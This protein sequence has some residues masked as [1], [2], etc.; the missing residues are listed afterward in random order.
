M[1][2]QTP[3]TL[4][5]AQAAE[6]IAQGGILAYPT[7]SVWGLGCD[8]F[9]AEAFKTLLALKERP[10]EK[11][12]ILVA[13]SRAQAAPYVAHLPAALQQKLHESWED[14]AQATTWLVPLAG[15]SDSV[16]IPAWLTGEHEA[17]ALRVTPHP[18]AQALCL[19]AGSPLVST[20]C[21]PAG[22]PPAKTLH[23]THAYFGKQVAYLAGNTLG[24]DAPSCIIDV[25]TQ[26][27][28]R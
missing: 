23:E 1:M 13:G 9:N 4:T 2:P 5:I 7:E 10:Q 14:T 3:P 22:K 24:F 15:M 17:V 21:N 19:A 8:P 26:K 20:S 28:L 6:H 16:H 25:L 12:V 11:G 27:Q 18:L